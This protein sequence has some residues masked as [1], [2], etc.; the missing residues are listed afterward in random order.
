MQMENFG[1][2]HPRDVAANAE[3]PMNY[4]PLRARQDTCTGMKSW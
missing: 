3:L 4:I 2:P 1:M